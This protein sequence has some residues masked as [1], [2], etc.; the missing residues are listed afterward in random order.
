[1]LAW[2]G[3][4]P[5]WHWALFA[6][7]RK[8]EINIDT[9]LLR[10]SLG[11]PAPSLDFSPGPVSPSAACPLRACCQAC[12]PPPKTP[13]LETWGQAYLPAFWGGTETEARESRVLVS[14]VTAS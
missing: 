4:G 6:H 10:H 1:M 5:G 8:K 11:K 13:H 12:L 3:G 14:S 7:L 2:G 9:G